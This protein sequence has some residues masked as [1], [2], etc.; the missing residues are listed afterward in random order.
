MKKTMPKL[1][2]STYPA[3]AMRGGLPLEYL[4]AEPFIIERFLTTD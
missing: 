2:A 1:D 3:V 4:V